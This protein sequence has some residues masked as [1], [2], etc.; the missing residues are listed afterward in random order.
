MNLGSGNYSASV[1]HW[2]TLHSWTLNCTALTRSTELGRSSHTA[3]E[4]TTENTACITSSSVVWR[5]SARVCCGHYLAMADIYR[6][7]RH[8]MLSGS[9]MWPNTE[10]TLWS[11]FLTAPVPLM[12]PVYEVTLSEDIWMWNFIGF[13]DMRRVC[14]N[15]LRYI[16]SRFYCISFT[17]LARLWGGSWWSILEMITLM[18]LDL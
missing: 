4:R 18:P 8:N 5:H 2:W 15:F 1:A 13:S 12:W 9:V 14:A 3:S 6:V 10:V 7:T 16:L 11:V 17:D